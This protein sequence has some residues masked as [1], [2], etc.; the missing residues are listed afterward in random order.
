[1][2]VAVN[3]GQE[4]RSLQTVETVPPIENSLTTFV[5]VRAQRV[6]EAT[7]A[8]QNYIT[9]VLSRSNARGILGMKIQLS[10]TKYGRAHVQNAQR[11]QGK[12]Y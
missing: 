8:N 5:M 2:Q 3:G 1:M 7:A 6:A 4:W 12:D 9:V 10:T 11:S